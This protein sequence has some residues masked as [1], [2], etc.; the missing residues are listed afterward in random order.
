MKKLTL[1]FLVMLCFG[2]WVEGGGLKPYYRQASGGP[3]DAT[4]PGAVTNIVNGFGFITGEGATN[5]INAA[6][7]GINLVNIPLAGLQTM[8][9]TNGW[10]T[11]TV[12]KLTELT[13]S[14]DVPIPAGVHAAMVI[15]NGCR[16]NTSGADF[17]MV[18]AAGGT[19]FNSGW[20]RHIFQDLGAS[21]NDANGTGINLGR[22]GFPGTRGFC[23]ATITG[24][25]TG[26]V[27]AWH[28]NLNNYGAGGGNAWWG[29]NSKSL[30]AAVTNFNFTCPGAGQFSNNFTL[31]IQVQ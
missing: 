21:F 25:D 23:V 24:L 15:W 29:A 2:V 10:K 31:V 18:P 14:I 9:L 5:A 3:V 22:I 16:T 8:P 12:L 4:T 13:A 6:T 1:V 26:E 20:I 7:N 17:L 19:A 27:G 28:Y 30:G 11:L